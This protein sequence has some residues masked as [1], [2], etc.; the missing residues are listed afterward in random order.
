MTRP[1]ARLRAAGTI[2]GGIK[3]FDLRGRAGAEDIV[4][5]GNTLRRAR[6]EYA[7]LGARTPRSAIAVG[8]SLDS[9]RAAGFAMDSVEIRSSYHASAG[10][11][12]LVDLSAHR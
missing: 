12:A 3:G 4:F 10:D 9:A 11:V 2:R 6:F 1:R 8:A 5:R 7:W